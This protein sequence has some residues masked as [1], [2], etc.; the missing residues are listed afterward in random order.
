MEGKERVCVCVPV[1]LICLPVHFCVRVFTPSLLSA[2]GMFF[3]L[4]NEHRP[5]RGTQMLGKR[6]GGA[7]KITI[8]N[9]KTLG[10]CQPCIHGCDEAQFASR[11]SLLLAVF[12]VGFNEIFLTKLSCDVQIFFFFPCA[13]AE[14]KCFLLFFLILVFLFSMILYKVV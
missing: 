1:M 6:R 12:A 9:R 11:R 13:H 8:I 4:E 2:A 14:V 5:K 10:V 7:V 3:L